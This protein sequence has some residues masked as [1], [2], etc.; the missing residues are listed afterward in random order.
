MADP[1]AFISFDFDLSSMR[2]HIHRSVSYVNGMGY[3]E[4][5]TKSQSGPGA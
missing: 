2:I 5:D 4:H 1:R 3:V